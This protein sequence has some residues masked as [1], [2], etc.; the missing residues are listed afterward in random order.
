[1]CSII[2]ILAHY[3]CP[4]RSSA[5]GFNI[6]DY[7]APADLE[8]LLAVR[9]GAGHRDR[10]PWAVPLFTHDPID[11]E[12]YR[13]LLSLAAVVA[14]DLHS[15]FGGPSDEH[16]PAG[17]RHP[18]DV[19]GVGREHSPY[20]VDDLRRR[21]DVEAE[22]VRTQ[23]G[24]GSVH[25][26]GQRDFAYLDRND[27]VFSPEEEVDDARD[28][29]QEKQPSATRMFGS[30][31]FSKTNRPDTLPFGTKPSAARLAPIVER[32]PSS[33][34][35]S[36]RPITTVELVAMLTIPIMSPSHAAS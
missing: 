18:V 9:V 3:Y 7:F 2:G 23:D 6:R 11:P 24:L 34:L 1:M 29:R 26:D 30:F 10:P 31:F 15:L 5:L 36:M 32:I 16:L 22:A 27:L 25:P 4:S 14:G 8:R 17:L 19:Y 33:S 13:D 20:L 28:D 21:G 35:S 12:R